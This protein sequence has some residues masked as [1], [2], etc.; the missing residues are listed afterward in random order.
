M[1]VSDGPIL[2]QTAFEQ[3]WKWNKASYRQLQ[4]CSML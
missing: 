2:P 3:Q 1:A 4:Q